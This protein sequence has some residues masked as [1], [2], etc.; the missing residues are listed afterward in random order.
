MSK[1]SASF[2]HRDNVQ[3]ASQHCLYCQQALE[4]V[5][6]H[7]HGLCGWCLDRIPDAIL[8]DLIQVEDHACNEHPLESVS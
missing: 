8:C 2:H 5:P 7:W 4:N 1:R 3:A 6:V